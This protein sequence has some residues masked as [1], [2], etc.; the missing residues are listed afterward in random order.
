[1]KEGGGGLFSTIGN[2]CPLHP[3]W[4]CAL[5]CVQLVGLE[6]RLGELEA[7]HKELTDHKYRSQAAIREL[8]AKLK[9]SEEVSYMYIQCIYNSKKFW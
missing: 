9:S 1:M 6:S 3:P 8:K 5:L 2:I 4:K 7:S